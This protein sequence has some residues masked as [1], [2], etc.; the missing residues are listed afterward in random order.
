QLALQG[1]KDPWQIPEELIARAETVID[2]AG[3]HESAAQAK[4]HAPLAKKWKIYLVELNNV[5]DVE[6]SEQGI[7]EGLRSELTEGQDFAVKIGNAQGDM[8]TLTGVIDAALSDGADMLITMSTP[9][10]QVALQRAQ[11]VPVVFTY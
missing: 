9:T 10:L 7:L 11:K 4:A 5:L 2:A 8:A 3:V 1:L 6:E